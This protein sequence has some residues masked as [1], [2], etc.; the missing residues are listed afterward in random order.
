MTMIRESFDNPDK[1]LNPLASTVGLLFLGTPFRGRDG[2]DLNQMVEA[3]A[4]I[5]SEE[6]VFPEVLKNNLA[7]SEFLIQARRKFLE[8]R[9]KDY[10]IP[11]CCFYEK[12]ST[13][14]AQIVKSAPMIV[15]VIAEQSGTASM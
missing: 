6:E 1:W 2:M 12:F 7:G 10:P 4:R 14:V 3:A 13:D 11:I 9:K 5:T 8:A 15:S